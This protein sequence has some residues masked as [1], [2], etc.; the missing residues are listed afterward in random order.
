M[1]DHA[2]TKSIPAK[3]LS[4]RA[5]AGAHPADMENFA[6]P[7]LLCTEPWVLGWVLAAALALSACAGKVCPPSEGD[8]LSRGG[9]DRVSPGGN[10]LS[11]WGG[12][13]AL[14]ERDGFR[15]L[16]DPMLGG[17][18][19][20][21]FFLPK[22][23]STGAVHAPVARYTDPPE[24]EL[25][26]L[27]AVLLSHG[28]A[29]H[30][31]DAARARL[32]KDGLVVVPPHILADLQA[33][34][35][36]NVKTLDWGESLTLTHGDVNLTITAVPAHHAHDPAA[37][38]QSLKVNGYVLAWRHAVAPPGSGHAG[39]PGAQQVTATAFTVYWTGDSVIF[40]GQA[41]AVAPFQPIDLLL[42][43]MGAVGSDG[44]ALK[45][46]DADELDALVAAVHPRQIIPIHHTT[47]SHYREPI[48]AVEQHA[49]RAGWSARLLVLPEGGQA[50]LESRPASSP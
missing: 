30:W 26:V 50:A 25:G 22:H 44:P 2:Q 47:F 3:V 8:A 35:F 18:G 37:D 1:V 31:D 24:R 4:A 27:D 15:V 17:R 34:G 12:P 36:R 9:R 6:E 29:D 40:P 11:W 10:Y 39:E 16:T 46:M 21:A 38:A 41:A 20:E 7:D 33:A 48:A 43:H 13:T 14:L 45:T 23:P 42:P 49:Q 28:H 32:P 5:A 19:K